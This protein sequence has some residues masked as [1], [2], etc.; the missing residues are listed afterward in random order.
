MYGVHSHRFN[1][2]GYR[3]F[4]WQNIQLKM[5]VRGQNFHLRDFTCLVLAVLQIV[6]FVAQAP[7]ST[8]SGCG[9]FWQ[10]DIS[11]N[12]EGGQGLNISKVLFERNQVK[13]MKEHADTLLLRLQ[14][15]A[16]RTVSCNLSWPVLISFLNHEWLWNRKHSR[17]FTKHNHSHHIFLGKLTDQFLMW[18][19][20]YAGQHTEQSHYVECAGEGF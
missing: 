17:S 15:L 14:N 2:L 6:G 4:F 20:A 5:D 9:G 18:R 7:L 16:V 13:Q 3:C 12:N 11:V 10:L 19:C 1:K 8:F